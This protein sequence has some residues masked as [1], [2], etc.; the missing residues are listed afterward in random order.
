MFERFLPNTAGEVY[1]L[2]VVINMEWD[3]KL[4]DPESTSYKDLTAT[5]IYAV[6][7][8]ESSEYFLS[9][10]YSF[11]VHVVALIK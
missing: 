7:F 1:L 8:L 9:R 6:S 11:L 3:N 5:L 4:T 10:V 2:S